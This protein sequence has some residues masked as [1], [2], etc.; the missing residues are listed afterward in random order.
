MSDR[1]MPALL[2]L[3]KRLERSW[4]AS[5]VVRALLPTV[6]NV[7]GYPHCWLAL[8]G[9]KPGFVTV[10]SHAASA[11]ND[12]ELL[13]KTNEI[14]IAIEG[15]PFLA[16]ILRADHIVVVGEARDD[17]RTNKQ[18]VTALGNRT[19]IN[20]PL[21]VAEG[22]LGT[23][24]LGTFGD[25][26]VRMPQPWQL[27][28]LQAAAGHVA[29][30]LD[31]VNFLALKASGEARQRELERQLEQAQKMESLGLLVG[32]VAHDMNN[33]LAAISAL[34]ASQ[35]QSDQTDARSQQA[36]QTIQKAIDRGRSMVRGI[37]DFSRVGL[38]EHGPVHWNTVVREQ[39]EL[40]SHSTLAQ[41]D[42]KV[43][44]A[45]D[46]PPIEGNA[47]AL[48]QLL[49][50]LCVNAVH[51]MTDSGRPAR[52]EIQTLL[53]DTSV[54]LIVSDNG[55]GMS[56]ETLTRATEPLFTTKGRKGTGLGL[57]QAVAIV[58]AHRGSLNLSS[59]LG[60]GTEV[61]A[62]FPLSGQSPRGIPRPTPES[63]PVSLPPSRVLLVDDDDMV[64]SATHDLLAALGNH[65]ISVSRA[66]QALD[67]LATGAPCDLVMLDIN[68]P[69]LGGLGALGQMHSLCPQMLIVLVTG[70]PDRAVLELVDAHEHLRLLI[71]PFTVGELQSA[72]AFAG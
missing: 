56:S 22:N 59:T 13:R 48:G 23:L 6:E 28:F 50:N 5:A 42:L 41:V 20:V 67:Y 31:R 72:M 70:L 51:A 40:L 39:I 71:K 11:G 57:S 49:M 32:G 10:V 36:F 33:V 25:E 64:R 15:D 14:E 55:V 54:V 43:H 61:R 60:Q 52:L 19:I 44:L 2:E 63:P 68:M 9:Q 21:L 35:Q 26:G 8:F 34:A 27:E 1:L 17:P 47:G 3:S 62:T 29:V 66:E 30:A 46:L 4:T 24:G 12:E 45:E 16:E 18:V 69:G 53:T 38:P 7:L 37:M 65:P 58:R